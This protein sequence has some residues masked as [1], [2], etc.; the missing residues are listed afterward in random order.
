MTTFVLHGGRTSDDDP[1]NT[2]FFENF[3]SLTQ[4]NKPN[5]LMC[6]WA[7]NQN[8][9][10]KKFQFETQQITQHAKKEFTSS[11]VHDVTELFQKLPTADVLYVAGGDAE[12]IEKFYPQLSDL[13]QALHNKVYLGSSM[14]AFLAS[15]YYVLSLADQD[16][17]SVH[18]GIG[19]L[20]ISTLCHWNVEQNRQNKIILLQK[21]A[22][23]HPILALNEYE[24]IELYQ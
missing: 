7:R 10:Q 8:E 22:P 9:W 17:N 16:E 19:L 23:N 21:S 14:G 6:Y 2:S 1:R 15:S 11:I 4:S 13:K 20:P 24:S 18:T 5:I 3:T 12:P